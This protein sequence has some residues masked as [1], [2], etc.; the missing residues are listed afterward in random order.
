MSDPDQIRADIERT[1]AGLSSD[2]NLLEE[3]VSPSKIMDR[4]VQSAKGTAASLKD[5]VMGTA[6]HHVGAAQDAGQGAADSAKAALSSVSGTAHD[7]P[8]AVAARA[9]GNPLAAGLIAFGVGWLASSV[10]A[11]TNAEQQAAAGLKAKAQETVQPAV[12]DAAKEVADHLREPA[13]QAVEQ[14]KGTAQ[15][16][17]TTVTEHARSVADDV[18]QQATT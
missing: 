15:D 8:G 13:Q 5:K 1:R 18:K 3:K 2:V 16:A 17:T 4:R 7:A 6:Q 10:F 11:P 12:T 14:V 9:Q